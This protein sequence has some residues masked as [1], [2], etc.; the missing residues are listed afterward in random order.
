MTTKN[1]LVTGA[2]GKQ[3]SAAVNALIAD[4]SDIT[5]FALTRNPESKGAKALAAK[6][7]KIRV[8]KGDLN[9]VESIFSSLNVLGGVDGVF[10][11]Q[12]ALGGGAN[13]ES[14]VRQGKAL[15]DYSIKNNVSHFVYTS[16]DRH[17]ES[18]TNIPHFKTKYEVEEH[19]LSQA[20]GTGMN[21]TILRPVFFMEN[22][23]PGFV[24]KLIGALWHS[25]LGSTPL[26]MVATKDIGVFAAKALL[27]PE[28][29]SERKIS[30][31][32]DEL[33]FDQANEIFKKQVGSNLPRTFD[34]VA[35]IVGYLVKEFGLMFQWFKD[36]GFGADVSALRREDP[37]LLSFED[38]LEQESNWAKKGK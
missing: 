37:Q 6:S 16:V 14:E 9:D 24:G 25:Y 11:V 1:I 27:Q 12:P 30:L 8:V 26:K 2:T 17:G 29:Y 36:V 7:E 21:W 23:T 5:V 31:A 10:S 15:I 13:A 4:S 35:N 33:T 28:E 19:L 32:G 3:G 22:L 20:E 34:F 18:P 38:W